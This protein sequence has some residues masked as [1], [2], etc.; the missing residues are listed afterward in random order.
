MI[1]KEVKLKKDSWHF[2]LQRFVFGRQPTY[3]NFCPYFWLT[4]FCVIISPILFPA[5][6][7]VMVAK[8]V[9]AALAWIGD[10]LSP[11]FR[12]LN[13]VFDLLV[14]GL[15]E[16]I[17]FLICMPLE[18]MDLNSLTDREVVDLY[19]HSRYRWMDAYSYDKD[20][21]YK[22]L[23]NNA[24][25]KKQRTLWARMDDRFNAWI[26]LAGDDWRS[27]LDDA[28]AKEQARQRDEHARAE[29]RARLRYEADKAAEAASR[30][31][32]AQR[33][34]TLNSIV[35]WT[36]RLVPF[37]LFAVASVLLY[38][39]WIF[40][41]FL[42]RIGIPQ[43]VFSSIIGIPNF[44]WVA[45]VFIV[46]VPMKLVRLFWGWELTA[47]VATVLFGFVAYRKAGKCTLY[48]TS[49]RSTPWWLSRWLEAL[50]DW[51]CAFIESVGNFFS[52]LKQ[53]FLMWKKDNCPQIIW[54]E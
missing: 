45:T 2:R 47:M 31:A 49:E 6:G 13:A 34:E 8:K 14:R 26:G 23:L 16:V 20:Y 51:F 12:P 36:K 43:A 25:S 9:P 7:L 28:I 37:L 38:V 30:D 50:G 24:E 40:A 3:S 48:L 19:Q 33:K 27:K 22:A 39:L 5:V 54:E 46:M 44:L 35:L 42:F 18:R 41:M 15:D 11:L 10:V 21:A 29:E 32:S 17:N 4:I 1:F 52:F 53:G